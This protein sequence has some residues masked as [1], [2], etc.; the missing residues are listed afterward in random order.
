VC[1]YCK[2]V[3]HWFDECCKREK[4]NLKWKKKS[5]KANLAEE[6]ENVIGYILVATRNLDSTTPTNFIIDS[7]ATT[8]MFCNK[9]SFS[10]YVHQLSVSETMQQSQ[11]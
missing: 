5:E 9:S 7:S 3:G 4:D 6:E 1:K 10:S 11:S 2:K 8:H